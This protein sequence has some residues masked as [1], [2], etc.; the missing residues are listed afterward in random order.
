MKM[1]ST[2]ALL[3]EVN[4]KFPTLPFSLRA[5]PLE[6]KEAKFGV[7]EAVRA[8]LLAAYPVLEEKAGAFTAHVR[9]T[10]L[11]L[12][13]GTLK[14]SGAELQP[15]VTSE[16]VLPAELAVIR[17]SVPYVKIVKAAAANAD[18]EMKA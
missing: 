14:V 3:S 13:G 10:V 11:L 16:K 8:G 7:S 2:R 6:E 12:P 17:A 18:V 4:K 1:K 5:L 9:F 15:W